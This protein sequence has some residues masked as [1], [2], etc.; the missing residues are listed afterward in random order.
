[1]M[2]NILKM[3]EEMDQTLP[4]WRESVK[5]YYKK[6]SD[7]IS[8]EHMEGYADLLNRIC[9]EITSGTLDES[10]AIEVFHDEELKGYV[11]KTIFEKLRPFRAFA[12]IRKHEKENLSAIKYMFD[13][14]WEQ[15]VVRF[16]PKI[17]IDPVD[18]I[19]EDEIGEIMRTMDAL[20][21]FCVSRTYSYEGILDEISTRF[22]ISDELSEYLAKRID[23]D[24]QKI[25][26]N[27]LIRRIRK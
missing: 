14:M 9:D 21:D 26:M 22:R 6:T 11:Q 13:V 1:M 8:D 25:Q 5:N 10:D 15:Y 19:T 17:N 24:Y 3:I 23:R 7:E 27:Y 2:E 12:P 16:N 4:E 18:S 20:A